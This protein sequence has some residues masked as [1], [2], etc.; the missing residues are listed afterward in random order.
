MDVLAL[1]ALSESHPM[2][3]AILVVGIMASAG[4]LLGR[5]TEAVMGAF[6][7]RGATTRADEH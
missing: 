1:S 6:G 3:F 5:V 2:G 4:A 7:I